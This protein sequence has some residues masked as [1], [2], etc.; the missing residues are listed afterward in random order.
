M[1]R[2]TRRTTFETRVPDRRGQWAT[3]SQLYE[4]AM[5]TASRCIRLAQ[6]LAMIYV[7]QDC[8]HPLCLRLLIPG[9]GP[10]EYVL[11]GLKSYY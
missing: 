1:R 4:L 3:G 9:I 7:R 5:D 8:A 6:A 10:V 2:S 11:E